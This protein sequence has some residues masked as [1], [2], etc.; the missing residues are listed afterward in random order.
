MAGWSGPGLLLVAL[1]GS[2]A[3][4]Q[5]AS[6]QGLSGFDGQYVGQLTLVE[7]IAG[8]CTPPPLGAL[9]PL[10]VSGGQVSFA[11]L[12]RFDTTLTGSIAANGNFKA[13]ARTKHGFVEM[14]GQIRGNAV[15]AQIVSPS[16]LY[17]FATTY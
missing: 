9:Y 14:T 17:N 15:N 5:I 11:Y 6:A 12:P 8:N 4:G 16:C 7:V 1:L 10:V 13:S 2:S 3:F